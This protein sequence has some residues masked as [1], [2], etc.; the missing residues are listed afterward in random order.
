MPRIWFKYTSLILFLCACETAQKHPPEKKINY[1]TLKDPLIQN[2]KERLSIEESQ[3]KAYITRKKWPVVKT[4]TG[5]R[6]YIY[7]SVY[8]SSV[9]PKAN[10]RVVISYSVSLLNGKVCYASSDKPEVFLVDRDD[11]ESGLHQGIKQLMVGQKAKIIL[12][13]YLA[14]GL[15]GDL[16]KIPPVSTIIYDLQLLRI[17]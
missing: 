16:D 1:Q 5:L 9:K 14:H 8:S 12:P 17:L 6:Y 15:A 3:I 13:S 10:D 4:Q 2:N 7:D 11:V